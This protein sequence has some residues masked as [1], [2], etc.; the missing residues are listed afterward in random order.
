MWIRRAWDH[1]RLTSQHSMRLFRSCGSRNDGSAPACRVGAPEARVCEECGAFVAL[2]LTARKG[3]LCLQFANSDQRP[4][5]WNACSLVTRQG[6]GA[7]CRRR[8]TCGALLRRGRR[9]GISCGCG[10]R[11][12]HHA[13][14]WAW[15]LRWRS[16]RFSP[17][18][19][20]PRLRALALP[21]WARSWAGSSIGD[22]R[23]GSPRASLQHRRASCRFCHADTPHYT[24]SIYASPMLVHA[25]ATPLPCAPQ[26]RPGR[27]RARAAQQ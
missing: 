21:R 13:H 14:R 3:R 18:C 20:S 2:P 8:R 12:A 25:S 24:S 19:V 11:I 6:L 15:L 5:C 4:L 10:A 22:R 16:R 27:C 26:T 1:G 23:E 9:L 7:E 17:S